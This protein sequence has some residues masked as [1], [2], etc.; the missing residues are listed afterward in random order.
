MPTSSGRKGKT[1]NNE[2]GEGKKDTARE[3]TKERKPF[4]K[5]MSSK[6]ITVQENE[7][8]NEEEEGYL[9]DPGDRFEP[10]E[11]EEGKLRRG[12]KDDEERERGDNSNNSKEENSSEDSA[13][14]NR[15]RKSLPREPLRENAKEQNT[16]NRNQNIEQRYGSR[17]NLDDNYGT[18][19]RES[20]GP[21]RFSTGKRKQ[22]VSSRNV[23]AR[24]YSE[25]QAK[26][27]NGRNATA[28]RSIAV[29]KSQRDMRQS[30]IVVDEQ[31]EAY[32]EQIMGY[33]F[34]DQSESFDAIDYNAEWEESPENVSDVSSF[35]HKCY[36][37]IDWFPSLIKLHFRYAYNDW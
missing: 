3:E 15:H 2:E 11:S 14:R 7:P 28:R 29:D 1:E 25:A 37:S 26:V 4:S 12:S 10:D 8:I 22:A 33:R 17:D 20:V 24:R 6:T 9:N 32:D 13:K 21:L 30:N 16:R 19:R 18:Q 27:D 34:N 31:Y 36:L 23:N 5:Q 35:V